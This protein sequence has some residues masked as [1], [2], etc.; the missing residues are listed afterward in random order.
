MDKTGRLFLVGRS[1][2]MII[3]GGYNVYP[4]E[5]EYVIEE[6]DCVLEAAV[7]GVDDED[8][9]ERVEAVVR[10]KKP[11]CIDE[12]SLLEFTR[13][14]L[15]HYKCPKKIYIVDEIPKNTMGKIVIDDIKKLIKEGRIA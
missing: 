4:K 7:L 13:N 15:A 11:G 2:N 9:G 3:S 5:V 1:N 12:K 10:L 8:F 6:N 14:K